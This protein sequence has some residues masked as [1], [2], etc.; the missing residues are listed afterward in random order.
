M[1]ITDEQRP[2]LRFLAVM[3]AASMVGVQGYAVLFNNFAVE[4]VGLDGQG[5]GVI[6]SVREVPGSWR[7]WR[8]TSCW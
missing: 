3:T 7:F 8:S 5:V 1:R 4:V 6:Q 2:M